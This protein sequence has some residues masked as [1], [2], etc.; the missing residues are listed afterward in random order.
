[1]ERPTGVP[2]LLEALGLGGEGGPLQKMLDKNMP[3]TDPEKTMDLAVSLMA[4][5]PEFQV[6]NIVCWRKGMK[7]KRFP[8]EDERAIV[9]RVCPGRHNTA[10]DAGS[11][12]FDE[13]LTLTVAA[14]SFN[15]DGT[16]DSINEYAVD[17]RR[18]MPAE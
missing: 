5:E 18:F 17:A 9:T 13:P 15:P 2:G 3:V 14:L 6:G 12:M 10:A 11:P 1:M 4:K 16:T 7:N 8:R